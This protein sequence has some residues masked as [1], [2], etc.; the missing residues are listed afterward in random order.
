MWPQ[1]SSRGLSFGWRHISLMC[2]LGIHETSK[3]PEQADQKRRVEQSLLIPFIQ[4]DSVRGHI[5]A[6]SKNDFCNCICWALPVLRLLLHSSGMQSKPP[7]PCSYSF[8]RDQYI[9]WWLRER[10]LINIGAK[11]A[12]TTKM[13]TVYSLHVTETMDL[14]YVIL[15]FISQ[16][17]EGYFAETAR[18]KTF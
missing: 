3:N 11:E 5:M 12:F 9:P 8:H 1:N 14:F 7:W 4:D 18:G 13:A 16:L 10:G 17:F 6:I 15:L 2:S